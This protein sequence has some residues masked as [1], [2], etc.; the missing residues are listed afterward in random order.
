MG[1]MV[2]S[3]EVQK[4]IFLTVC[5][6]QQMLNLFYSPVGPTAVLAS[7]I[8][9]RLLT[10]LFYLLCR[11][12]YLFTYLR[13]TFYLAWFNYTLGLCVCFFENTDEC[14]FQS[15]LTFVFLL[16]WFSDKG[17]FFS[18][19]LAPTLTWSHDTE[20]WVSQHPLRYDWWL[21]PTQ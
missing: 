7:Y 9:K 8:V 18:P 19:A 21:S 4:P 20:G 17:I 12:C 3:R 14:F 6:F 13:D 15:V 10:L 11:S 2:V 1:S 16:T 5:C